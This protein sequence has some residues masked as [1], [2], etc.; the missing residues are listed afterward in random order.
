MCNS[1]QKVT[2]MHQTVQV[3]GMS[4]KCNRCES[5]MWIFCSRSRAPQVC[6]RHGQVKIKGP[7]SRRRT[8][9]PFFLLELCFRF[10]H[11]VH[12]HLSHFFLFTLKIAQELFPLGLISLLKTGGKKRKNSVNMRRGTASISLPLCLQLPTWC[13]DERAFGPLP[14]SLPERLAVW[15]CV[16]E[17]HLL[18]LAASVQLIVASVGLLPQILHVDSDQHLS[19]FYKVAVTLVLNWGENNT[20][21]LGR[22]RATRSAPFFFFVFF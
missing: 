17:A 4:G 9:L 20:A 7:A 2:S 15:I 1:Q 6:V 12:K 5:Q 3:C 22:S 13:V 14:R 8:D 11:F 19:E 21:G 10:F 18:Q 16:F